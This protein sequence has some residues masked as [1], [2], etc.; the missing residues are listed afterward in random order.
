MKISDDRLS[1]LGSISISNGEYL[2]PN[3]AAACPEIYIS[4]YD[5][6]KIISVAIRLD[7]LEQAW[8][9]MY[10]SEGNRTDEFNYIKPLN[11]DLP[12]M[13]Q[14]YSVDFNFNSDIFDEYFSGRYSEVLSSFALVNENSDDN[15]STDVEIDFESDIHLDFLIELKLPPLLLK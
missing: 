1:G 11:D 14:N 3:V 4:D 7:N 15:F 8:M 13:W 10:F 6:R 2:F 12:A 9:S 5:N